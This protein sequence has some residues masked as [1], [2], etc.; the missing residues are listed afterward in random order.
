M[1]RL[2]AG[3]R[4]ALQPEGSRR[5]GSLGLRTRAA[6]GMGVGQALSTA[7]EGKPGCR[8]QAPSLISWMVRAEL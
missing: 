5:V 4:Q 1:G 3:E 8:G 7:A 6:D 2:L